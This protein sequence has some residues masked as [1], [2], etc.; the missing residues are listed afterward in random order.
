MEYFLSGRTLTLN[1]V[2]VSVNVYFLVFLMLPNQ[3]SLFTI[4]DDVAYLNCAYMSPL[5]HSAVDAGLAGIRAKAHPWYITAADF[6]SDVEKSRVLAASIIG[7]ANNDIA[8]IPSA[9]YGVATA[10]NNLDLHPDQEIIVL[11]EQFPSNIYGWMETAKVSGAR[12]KTVRHPKDGDWTQAILNAINRK[13]GIAAL[14]HCHWTDGGLI[15]LELVS[16][17]LKKYNAALVIDATQSL[18]AM[19]LDISMIQPDFLIAACYKWLLGPYSTGILYVAPKHQNG[20]PI[21]FGWTDR[22]GAENFTDLTKYREGYQNG[23]RRFDVGE[24]SNFALLPPLITGLQQIDQW[25]VPSIYQ[26]ISKLTEF[27]MIRALECG[28][29]IRNLKYRAGHFLGIDLPLNAPTNL[30]HQLE[31][32]G[33]FVSI[34]GK[35][36]RVTPHVYNTLDDIQLLFKHLNRLI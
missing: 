8:L 32:E 34:R 33:V 23:A 11:E 30:T 27:A 12:L 9:S 1:P 22:A 18:G 10:I 3:R 17:S 14:P 7:C 13:T 16:D 19:P 5:L 6:F 15:N 24:R 4:P 35:S 25:G 29:K 21:E 2:C 36:L 26:T 31:K 28:L 20:R